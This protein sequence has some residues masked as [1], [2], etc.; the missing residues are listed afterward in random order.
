MARFGLGP[1]FNRIR[2]TFTGKEIVGI[3][4]FGNSFYSKLDK[5]E[6]GHDF[7][8]RTM[9][10][11]GGSSPANYDPEAINTLWRQW[12]SK[13]RREP[14]TEEEILRSVPVFSI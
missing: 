14:P 13:T 6:F 2:K 4:G 11:P 1:V 5:D 7:E 8:R 9:E 3:D 10:P 12:L